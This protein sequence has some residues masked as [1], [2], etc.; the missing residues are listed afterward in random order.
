M[1][2]SNII[3]LSLAATLFG[4]CDPA[5]VYNITVESDEADTFV[6]IDVTVT[7]ASE[8]TESDCEP[9]VHEHSGVRFNTASRPTVEFNST[10]TGFATDIGDSLDIGGAFHTVGGCGEG[11]TIEQIAINIRNL[12]SV[13]LLTS[14]VATVVID[15]HRMSVECTPVTYPDGLVEYW[16]IMDLSVQDGEFDVL[17]NSNGVPFQ[18]V[19]DELPELKSGEQ[20]TVTLYY[21]WSDIETGNGYVDGGGWAVIDSDSFVIDPYYADEWC[22]TRER[23]LA[24]NDGDTYGDPNNYLFVAVCD[25]WQDGYVDWTEGRDDCD[26]NNAD[27]YPGNG[28]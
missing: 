22:Y 7:P 3:S 12:E 18:L 9:F 25:P 16:C 8:E 6:D 17:P 26:D 2:R 19:L 24:D 13:D 23:R 28:C 14:T 15:G 4:G 10:L 1:A 5:D 27:V 21:K 20:S 11:V